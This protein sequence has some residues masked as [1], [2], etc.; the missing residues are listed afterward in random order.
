[1]SNLLWVV[2]DNLYN[3]D[4]YVRFLEALERL[5]C[6]YIIVKPVPFTNILLPSD[7]DSAVDEVDDA[8]D[9]IADDTQPIMICGATSLSRIAKARNWTPGTFLNDNF[10][11]EKWVEGFGARNM[12][13]D[14][15]TVGTIADIEYPIM[16]NY[17][18]RP[19]EDTKAIS[20]TV[21]SHLEFEIWLSTIQLME[22]EE[23]VPLHKNTEIVVSPVKE[24]YAE[25]RMFIV[26]CTVVAGSRYKMGNRVIGHPLVDQDVKDFAWKMA[27]AW[28]PA[29]AYVMDIARTEDGLKVIE[30]NNINSAG[31]YEADVY[32]IIDSIERLVLYGKTKNPPFL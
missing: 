4:G 22:E 25:Y 1:M 5:D 27:W 12:L 6:N 9:P 2:Q 13:N 11:Y 31:F 30:V 15:G 8:I 7:F 3:E 32:N 19:T 24:I 20:G 29:D 10:H 26:D 21:M 18:V 23:F 28:Q 16:E 17:F 14:I